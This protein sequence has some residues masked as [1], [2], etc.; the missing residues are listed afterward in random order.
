M[1]KWVK[2]KRVKGKQTVEK[3]IFNAKDGFLPAQE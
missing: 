2:G 3:L 1:G